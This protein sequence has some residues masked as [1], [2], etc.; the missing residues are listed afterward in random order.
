MYNSK[1]D[2]TYRDESRFAKKWI[3]W[4]VG[5]VLVCGA[6]GWVCTRGESTV[7]TAI[8]QYEDFQEIYNTCQKIDADLA[9]VRAVDDDDRM[10][11]S[12]SKS[13]VIA[14]K[15]QLMTRWCEEYNARSKMWNRALWKSSSLPYQL[16]PTTFPNYNP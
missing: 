9:T 6:I 5:L 1:Y 8:I 2:T 3:L 4:V 15:K 13:A 16:D 14:Q 12:F 7:R 11:D 10:F